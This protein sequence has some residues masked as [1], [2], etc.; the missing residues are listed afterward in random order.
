MWVTIWSGLPGL[1]LDAGRRRYSHTLLPGW[2]YTVAEMRTEMIEDL[3]RLADTGER[4][5]VATR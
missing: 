2:E 1:M 5:K 4:P 3:E